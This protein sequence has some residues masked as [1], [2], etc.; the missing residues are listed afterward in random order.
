MRFREA[1]RQCPLL[2]NYGQSGGPARSGQSRLTRLRC[3][4]QKSKATCAGDIRYVRTMRAE[5]GSHDVRHGH[6]VC[7]PIID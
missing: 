7:A 1:E 2:T 6:V 4:G 5:M 3:K